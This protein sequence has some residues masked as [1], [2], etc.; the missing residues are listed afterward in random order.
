M[1]HFVVD[2]FDFTLITLHLTF[3]DGDTAESVRELR[4][5]LDLLDGY[6][7]EPLHDP[8]VVVCGDFNIP[9]ALSGQPGFGF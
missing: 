4:T 7:Q 8:D 9:S 2:D 5:L 6:F 3:A 1:A